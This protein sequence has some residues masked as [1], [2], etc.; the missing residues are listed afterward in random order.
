VRRANPETRTQ[1]AQLRRWADMLVGIPLGARGA[2]AN[3]RTPMPELVV[4]D[5]E[6]LR[7]ASFLRLV[8]ARP[9][10]LQGLEAR[11]GRGQPARD[12]KVTWRIAGDYEVTLERLGKGEAA[13]R[14]VG[15]AWGV[16]RTVVMHARASC[17]KSAQ[18]SD[19]LVYVRTKFAHDHPGA[20]EAEI[21]QGISEELRGSG[22][23]SE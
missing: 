12:A 3:V 8:A 20:A 23:S 5:Y 1:V 9:A 15:Q 7:V 14:E 21:L 18:W 16:G 17:K 22:N 2:A 13:W 6:R 10:V 19:W 11:R 4:S